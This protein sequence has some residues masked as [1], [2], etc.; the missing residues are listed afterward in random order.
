MT[1]YYRNVDLEQG[2]TYG[3]HQL[4]VLSLHILWQV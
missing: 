3:K 2:H 1:E 4:I